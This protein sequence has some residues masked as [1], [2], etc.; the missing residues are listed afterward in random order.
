MARKIKK[1]LSIRTQSPYAKALSHTQSLLTDLIDQIPDVIYFKDT[2]GRLI[3]VNRAHAQGLG[4][5]PD[6]VAGKTDFDIFP[7][8]RAKAMARDDDYVMRKGKPIIDKIEPGT[9]A[10]GVDTHD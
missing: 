2:Q 1:T 9:R 5:K 7:R 8:E 10:D 3:L 4:L 6:E